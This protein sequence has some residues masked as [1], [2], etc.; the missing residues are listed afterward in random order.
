MHFLIFV[1]LICQGKVEISQGKV[2]EF[3]YLV[4][5]ATLVYQDNMTALPP[6]VLL[7]YWPYFCALAVGFIF[8]TQK[9][10]SRSWNVFMWVSLFIG[11]G[12]LMSLYS[13]EWYAQQRCPVNPVSHLD[14]HEVT[15]FSHTQWLS[16][17][18]MIRL[19]PSSSLSSLLSSAWT[20]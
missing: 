20:F 7:I 16:V 2:R 5:V 9:K 11:D 12:L 4:W 18:L 10:V 1:C 15:L 19:C 6:G 17:T 8:L 14:I 3:W 13:M